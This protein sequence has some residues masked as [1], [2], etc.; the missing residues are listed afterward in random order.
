M[1]EQNISRSTAKKLVYL[2]E[3]RDK[4]NA[5]EIPDGTAVKIDTARIL[6]NHGNKLTNYLTFVKESRGKV[7]HVSRDDQKA[8]NAMV[9]LKEDDSPIKWL[10]H[11]SDLIVVKEESNV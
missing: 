7:F 9:V 3:L 10:F 6:A 11:T 1:K 5:P 8:N 2:S 4:A